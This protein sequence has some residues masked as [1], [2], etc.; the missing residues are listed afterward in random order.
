MDQTV[1]PH[2]DLRVDHHND[3]IVQLR[4]LHDEA[5]QSYYQ[6]FRQTM[7][8]QLPLSLPTQPRWLPKA[9]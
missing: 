7:P 9:V 3:P 2:L 6:S 8:A 4:L 5:H 1:Y